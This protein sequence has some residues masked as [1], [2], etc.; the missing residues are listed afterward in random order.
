MASAADYFL[1]RDV[2]NN[3]IPSAILNSMLLLAAD[4]QTSFPLFVTRS[5]GLL[6]TA[7]CLLLWV[8]VLYVYDFS[9]YMYDLLSP[10]MSVHPILR[11]GL[12]KLPEMAL[13][14][15]TLQ[16]RQPLNQ[17]FFL[18]LWRSWNY[19]LWFLDCVSVKRALSSALWLWMGYY[20]QLEA[21]PSFTL[22]RDGLCTWSMSQNQPF[23]HCID[24]VS[25]HLPQHQKK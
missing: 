23:L 15:L 12:T 11:L 24:F 8:G 21:S 3:C 17:W 4:H 2:I 25:I 7:S 13:D 22:H 16:P 20:K 19:R 6:L 14:W 5:T 18:S 1:S 9:L 10:G